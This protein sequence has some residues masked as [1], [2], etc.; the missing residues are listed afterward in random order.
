MTDN[1]TRAW[2][3]VGGSVMW[4]TWSTLHSSGSPVLAKMFPRDGDGP[5]SFQGGGSGTRDDPFLVD[6]DADAFRELLGSLRNPATWQVDRRHAWVLDK[7]GVSGKVQSKPKAS[8]RGTG[9][10]D[11]LYFLS[12]QL[13]KS[14]CMLCI[15]LACLKAVFVDKNSHHIHFNY[16]PLGRK[17]MGKEY[18]GIFTR[19]LSCGS[20]D[21]A[22][23]LFDKI[24][25]L[26]QERSIVLQGSDFPNTV[27]HN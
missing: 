5:L 22:L 17:D 25:K 2:F 15:P 20:Q 6:E 12:D 24:V 16:R 11:C 21:G 13:T 23:A 19:T 27:V 3:D 26:L 10:P 1:G 7:Y 9:T 18:V 14:R 8:S 4:T